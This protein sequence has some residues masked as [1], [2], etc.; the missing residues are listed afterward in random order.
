MYET[1]ISPKYYFF[2]SGVQGSFPYFVNISNLTGI[3]HT[4][5]H[6]RRSMLVSGRIEYIHH[7]HHHINMPLLYP[8]THNN[9]THPSTHSTQYFFIYLDTFENV[10][11]LVENIEKTLVGVYVGRSNNL[12]LDLIYGVVIRVLVVRG[13]LDDR[14]IDRQILSNKRPTLL[15]LL[16][17]TDLLA[18]ILPWLLGRNTEP[19]VKARP[20]DPKVIST[21]PGFRT[22]ILFVR[23]LVD[24]QPARVWKVVHGRLGM[25]ARFP[26]LVLHQGPKDFVERILSDICI[27]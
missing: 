20:I 26:A 1:R 15:V 17:G 14:H 13:P 6:H 18:V 21:D 22:P 25:P 27:E 8:D 4:Y 10:K 2:D 24:R 19:D 12:E 7:I 16:F 3:G 5:Y 23:F 9:E 11:N